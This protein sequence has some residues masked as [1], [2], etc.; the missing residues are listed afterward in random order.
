[1][2]KKSAWGLPST[3][4]CL[5]P[6]IFSA[7]GLIR[8][9]MPCESVAD[10]TERKQE[11]VGAF[12]GLALGILDIRD[13]VEQREEDPAVVGSL[14]KLAVELADA[15]ASLVVVK[16]SCGMVLGAVLQDFD[17]MQ[18]LRMDG[19]GI[20]AVAEQFVIGFSRDRSQG[21]IEELEAGFVACDDAEIV[22]DV[23]CHHEGRHVVE[24]D[25]VLLQEFLQFRVQLLHLEAGFLQFGDVHRRTEQQARAVLVGEDALDAPQVLVSAVPGLHVHAGLL[26][27][28]LRVCDEIQ[29]ALTHFFGE[30]AG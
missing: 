2:W 19:L 4:F 10:G 15:G 26:L 11:A 24:Q 3:L 30:F 5:Q 21:Q 9:T 23:F 28:A 25:G 18:V 22:V 20:L 16:R 6:R 14:D 7:F 1:M 17:G 8:V 29:V 13:I 12:L 27:A